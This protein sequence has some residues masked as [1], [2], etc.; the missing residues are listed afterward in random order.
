[1]SG[2]QEKG[3]DRQI[4]C[5]KKKKKEKK[6]L[7]V[8]ACFLEIG[9]HQKNVSGFWCFWGS[10]GSRLSHELS[11][12]GQ[13]W[14]PLVQVG[15]LGT[16]IRL[17]CWVIGRK[18]ICNDF[19]LLKVTLFT[20]FNLKARATGFWVSYVW[21]TS[22]SCSWCVCLKTSSWIAKGLDIL[23]E[24]SSTVDSPLEQDDRTDLETL[25]KH[26]ALR[27]YSLNQCYKILCIH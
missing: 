2:F 15:K 1:M 25:N 13:Y 7:N 6:Y 10:G 5:L 26:L 19:E 3:I 24:I 27:A 17:L 4:H 23:K 9:C 8:W 20:L 16:L 21:V 14:E 11:N 18:S 12:L 22:A